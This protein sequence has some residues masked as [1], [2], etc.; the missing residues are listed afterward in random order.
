MFDRVGP[1]DVP[2]GNEAPVAAHSCSHSWQI[3]H[4]YQR[5]G[6]TRSEG[7]GQ[8]SE[9]GGETPATWQRGQGGGVCVT[10]CQGSPQGSEHSSFLRTDAQKG[11]TGTGRECDPSQRGRSSVHL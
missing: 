6:P 4:S 5:P 10:F 8:P 1:G 9:G 11:V 3:C 2:G 7:A